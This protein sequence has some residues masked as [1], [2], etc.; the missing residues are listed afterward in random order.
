M[1]QTSRTGGAPRARA[2]IS[3]ARAAASRGRRALSRRVQGG[4]LP[5]LR[6]ILRPR[7]RIDASSDVVVSFTSFP[8][9]IGGVWAVVDT[10]FRQD[11]PLKAVVLVLREQHFPGQRLPSS[12]R[13]RVARGLTILWVEHD[14]RSYDK[15]LPA[16][17]A[18]P[19]DRIITFDDDKIYAR[20]TASRLIQVSDA[21]PGVIVGS[22]GIRTVRNGDAI[23]FAGAVDYGRCAA[24][25][26]LSGYS[27]L[28]PPDSL[29]P[30]VFDYLTAVRLCP[31]GD[32]VWFWAMSVRHGTE[33]FCI[34]APK[35]VSLRRQEATP[36]L[37]DEYSDGSTQRQIAAVIDHFDLHKAFRR[38]G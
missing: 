12:L 13:R 35:H 28:Y 18:F 2:L 10:V 38:S 26:I 30:D 8:A 16:R 15:L 9:R 11:V 36:S 27:I 6:A 24:G 37:S 34:A 29:H 5:Y 33:R 14:Q 3:Q 19:H 23:E 31:S 4:P 25:D 1:V 32:D 17:Q 20:D 7:P 21:S 22:R